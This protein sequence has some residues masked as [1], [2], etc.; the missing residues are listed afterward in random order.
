MNCAI[1]RP[2][3]EFFEKQIATEIVYNGKVIDVSK[4]VALLK[5]GKT[6][7]RDVVHHKGG[8]TIIAVENNKILLI[9]Q[10]RYP[11]QSV[12]TE[13]PAG[14]LDKENESPLLAAKRELKE[15]TGF[16]AAKW[17]E[18]G[19]V[20][21]T[22]GFSNE[23]LYLFKATELTKGEQNLEDDEFI[24][25]EFIE[26]SKIKE[27]IQNNEITDAKTICAITRALLL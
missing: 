14:K 8:V 19:F 16:S 10:Y 24:K 7:Q 26:I 20:Y 22:P 15:E 21:S 6:A 5:N 23:K 1:I 18:L 11:I 9:H 2:M 4:D 3:E 13:L 27:M 12:L 17:Q 25:Y